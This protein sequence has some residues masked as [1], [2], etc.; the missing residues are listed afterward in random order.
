[1][2]VPTDDAKKPYG[3]APAAD[4]VAGAREDSETGE[5]SAEELQQISGGKPIAVDWIKGPT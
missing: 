5:L 1:M 4:A 3:T 2:S